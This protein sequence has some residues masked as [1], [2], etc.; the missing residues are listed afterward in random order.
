MYWAT[1]I[2]FKKSPEANSVFD[3]MKMIQDN[4]NHYGK[5]YGFRPAPYRND[6]AVSI[7]LQAVYGHTIPTSVEIP[8]NLVNVE[9]DTNIEMCNNEW[10]IKFERTVDTKTKYFKI[11]T[12]GQDLHV[13]NKDELMRIIDDTGIY[14]T[15]TE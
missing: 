8:W 9:F 11:T 2:Y 10:T 3:M 1:V 6:Y 7:A 4:Y 12:S 5:I 13:L 14:N 15:G